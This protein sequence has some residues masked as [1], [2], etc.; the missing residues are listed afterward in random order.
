MSDAHAS[1]AIRGHVAPFARSRGQPLADAQ[2]DAEHRD[3]L[4]DRHREQAEAHLAGRDGQRHEHVP[5]HV[6]DDLHHPDEAAGEADLG[7]CDEVGDVALERAARDVGAEAEQDDERGQREDRGGRRDAEQEHDVEQRPEHD[8]GLATA[9]PADGEVADV[10]DG[11]LDDDP[12]DRAPDADQ[13]QRRPDV[14]L[15]H[16]VV[17]LEAVR[18]EQADGGV[19]RR[20][21]QPVERDP[22][23]LRDREQGGRAGPDVG[24]RLPQR[25]GGGSHATPPSPPFA[26][27]R[28]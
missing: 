1:R 18:D 17:E 21:A 2:G 23:E 5:G 13:E 7:L 27:V 28:R 25:P 4:D 6:A 20:E 16:E 22:N 8:V 12:D 19:D 24:D 26:A 11:R 3:Q 15:G 10:A 9:P 14:V